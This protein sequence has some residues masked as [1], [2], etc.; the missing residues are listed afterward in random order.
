MIEHL[1]NLIAA[2]LHENKAPMTVG[3]IIARMNRELQ[4]AQLRLDVLLSLDRRFKRADPNSW[5]LNPEVNPQPLIAIKVSKEEYS[6]QEIVERAISL[7]QKSIDSLLEKKA[8]LEGEINVIETRLQ[9][10]QTSLVGLDFDQSPKR[11]ARI[12]KP[13]VSQSKKAGSE[14]DQ[15]YRSAW[16]LPGEQSLLLDNLCIILEE[17]NQQN[18]NLEALI[19]W[20]QGYFR[21][22]N[23]AKQSIFSCVI[24][25]GFA[26]CFS[27]Q[28]VLTDLGRQYLV[29][30]DA[31]LIALAVRQSF[32]GIEELLA[33][34]EEQPLTMDQL[35]IRF[36]SLGASWEKTA[37]IRYRLNWLIASGLVVQEPGS[38]P[39]RFSVVRS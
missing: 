8:S 39:V 20:F 27:G 15:R 34:L 33:W 23:W 32:W 1:L 30:R 9:E 17:I 36:K 21:V 2:L 12:M 14:P 10:I 38:R 18:P 29:S 25:P 26:E 37:Q 16:P 6:N 19:H 7:R 24:Y 31:T 28:V 5:S 22:G 35:H 4:L 11:S 3:E 13:E